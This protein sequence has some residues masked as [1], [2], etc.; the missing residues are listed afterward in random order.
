MND[1]FD[2]ATTL[3]YD[4]P[5]AEWLEALPIGN[6]RLGAMAFGRPGT[7]RVQFNADTL[8]A[9]GHDVRDD[10]VAREHLEEVRNLIFDG[11]VEAAQALAERKLMGDPLRLR[12]YQPFGDLYL[13]V[14]HDAADVTDYRREL[15]IGSGVARVRYDVGETTYARE[16]FASAPDDA[17]VLRLTADGPDTV[18]ATV[19]LD[20]AKEARASA[21]E[22]RLVLRG[23]VTDPPSPDDQGDGGWGLRF[24]A[25]ASIDADGGEVARLDEAGNDAGDDTGTDV[26][27]DPPWGPEGAALAVSDADAVTVVL[28]GFTDFERDD[29][30]A[31]CEDVLETARARPY[32][33][34][35]RVHVADHRDLFDRVDLDLGDPVDAPTDERLERVADGDDDPHLAALYFQFGRY[36]LMASSRSGTQ[37]ANL[38]G[39]WNEEY[40]PAWHSC[41]TL[42]VN[43]EMNYWPAVGT[44][45][46]E[47]AEPLYEFVDDLREPGR[48]TAEVHYGCEGFTAHLDSDLWRN[49]A[50]N[51][52][53]W[54]GT[55]PMAAAWLSRLCWDHYA[56]TRD[57]AYLLETAYPILREA[58]A[59]V[60]DF[61]VEH[62]E[63]GWLVTVPSMSPENAYRTDDGQE[64]TITYAPTMDVQLT[65]D[66]FE[67][68]V[69]AAE[70]LGV[71]DGFHD[72]LEAAAD[73][74]PPLQI[75]EHG[76]LQ[77]W[78]EDYEEVDPGH[79]HIS[80]L[81][82]A[83]PGD[84]ITPRE[85]PELAEAVETTLERRLDHGG[86]HT[87]WSAAWTVNQF[88]RLEDGERA[89]DVLRKLLVDSTAP[90]LFD[91]HPP[92][93]I[94]GNFGG[95]AGIAEMLVG[96]H[97]GEIRLLP[98][99]PDAWD[100]GSVEGLCA[101]GDFEVDV[102][103]NDGT[104]T[105][106]TIRSGSGE[107]CRL[108]APAGEIEVT[109]GDGDRVDVVRED[110]VVAFDTDEG[111]AYGVRIEG[112]N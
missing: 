5:A 31:A 79:R 11:E 57:E 64:A 23:Q 85:T 100:E 96:S 10:P 74:L 18:D 110:G 25:R 60:L 47:C 41:Y 69:A 107:R 48:R 27:G 30:A 16:Y 109:T 70:T 98:A 43:L 77:E 17:V 2:P 73:R 81:Y 28:T 104:V 4:G 44:N 63:E 68:C 51:A 55:W 3:W 39:V 71:R 99:L 32:G 40:E 111:A 59:F 14:G 56:F 105:E 61:L 72:D 42:N 1:E 94:D 82:D 13:D 12:P 34:L 83:H 66:L 46:A 89:H 53:S 54:W 7:D 45:L 106:A 101:R 58:A 37:P 90:N 24:E 35:R 38:Q 87:G 9:G 6:G 26:P 19:A 97:A 92:F 50:P 8:W 102:A 78:I 80:H 108:R 21:V 84:R 65:R 49:T 95:T 67:H 29:L 15:D 86:G 36:A 33:D 103:W 62:P 20:R 88:A 91:L 76:Q 52:G 93:Q 75:G 22:D 112:A